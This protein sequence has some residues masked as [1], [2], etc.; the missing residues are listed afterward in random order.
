MSDI[1][2][3]LQEL[4]SGTKNQDPNWLSDTAIKLSTLLYYHNTQTAEAELAENQAA[5]ELLELMTL[6]EGEKKISVAEAGKKAVVMTENVY[7]KMKLQGEAIVE[8]IQSCKKK[9]D[10]LMFERKNG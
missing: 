2:T 10:F 1:E 4:N 9:L 6:V 8:V 7:G 5:I 3:I